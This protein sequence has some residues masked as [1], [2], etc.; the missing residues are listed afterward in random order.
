MNTFKWKKHSECYCCTSR[1][2]NHQLISLGLHPPQLSHHCPLTGHMTQSHCFYHRVSVTNK[3]QAHPV[4]RVH[5]LFPFNV[6]IPLG[7]F[8]ILPPSLGNASNCHCQAAN[9]QMLKVNKVSFQI[10][11]NPKIFPPISQIKQKSY[12]CKVLIQL[13]GFWHLILNGGLS[14]P[15]RKSHLH[16][17]NPFAVKEASFF[18][19]RFFL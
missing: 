18:P 1:K 12:P 11:L 10:Y 14:T 7:F 2:L 4:N 13:L 17:I 15:Y 16:Q 19:E 3:S 9:Q 8:G 6:K 5:W